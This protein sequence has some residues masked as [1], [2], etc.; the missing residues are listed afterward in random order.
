MCVLS[1]YPRLAKQTLEGWRGDGD[2]GS[3]IDGGGTEAEGE[4]KRRRRGR[5]TVTQILLLLL[6]LQATQPGRA[7]ENHHREQDAH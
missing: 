6:P 3:K 5:Y 7:A 2:Y 1:L 4:R